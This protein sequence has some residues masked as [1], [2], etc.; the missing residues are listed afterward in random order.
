MGKDTLKNAN[1]PIMEIG[2]VMFDLDGTLLD[3]ESQ[4]TG[5]WDGIGCELLETDGMGMKVKGVSLS[6]VLQLY[7]KGNVQAQRMVTQCLADFE[8]DM[9]YGY[10]DGAERFLMQLK[11]RGIP[12]ALVTGTSETKMAHVYHAHPDFHDMFTVVFTGASFQ[13]SKPAPDCY[14]MAMQRLGVASS[15]TVVFEDSDAGLQAARAAGATVVGLATT[16]PA[17]VVAQKADFVV[18]DYKDMTVQRLLDIVATVRHETL[19]K[20]K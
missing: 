17:D 8:R 9:D 4:Y 11:K 7:F 6:Q 5:F 19:K 3:T 13:H 15:Q 18:S 10:I 16:R 20:Q 12:T 2:A 14:L 1:E